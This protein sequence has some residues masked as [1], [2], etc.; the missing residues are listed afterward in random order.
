MAATW[1]QAQSSRTS[2]VTDL[3]RG[4]E[5]AIQGATDGQA[6]GIP[7]LST[8]QPLPRVGIAD[9]GRNEHVAPLEPGSEGIEGREDIGAAVGHTASGVEGMTLPSRPHELGRRIDHTGLV[10]VLDATEV[11]EGSNQRPGVRRRCKLGS[12][13]Q[14]GEQR[15]Y[16]PPMRPQFLVAPVIGLGD[17]AVDAGHGG[18]DVEPGDLLEQRGLPLGQGQIALVGGHHMLAD[19]AQHD[20][21]GVEVAQRAQPGFAVRLLGLA[22]DVGCQGVEQF[23]RIVER[24]G[25]QR[26]EQSRQSGGAPRLLERSQVRR[27]GGAGAPRQASQRCGR[28]IRS[29]RQGQAV[30][31]DGFDALQMLQQFDRRPPPRGGTEII[32]LGERVVVGADQGDQLFL[33]LG[34]Q[35]P[36]QTLPKAQRG[37]M[38]HAAGQA[39]QRGDAGEQHFVRQ[40]PGG[41][42]VEQQPGPVIARPAQDIEPPGQS[43]PGSGIILEVAKPI[44]LA[45]GRG[46]PP[47]LPTIAVGIQA[48]RLSLP[49]LARHGLNHGRR[50]LG[51]IVEKSAEEARRPELDREAKPVMRTPHPTDQLAVGGIE[52]EVASELLLVGIAGVAAVSGKLFVGQKAA[53]HRVRNSGLSQ[54]SGRGPKIRHLHAANIPCG[55]STS[56]DK[57]RTLVER[58]P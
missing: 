56:C 32:E 4:S 16:P 7:G 11:V 33:L 24:R 13:Q 40:Q 10:P 43:E 25:F 51:R 38:A 34:G 37:A 12:L 49:E 47:S 1:C 26:L 42:P 3:R 27:L 29:G 58:L 36:G 22:E 2:Q 41:R 8:Q 6:C 45:D 48:R 5:R 21:G 55:I 52:M 57:F 31:A 30:A 39:F 54:K 14:A 17:Q 9:A 44:L 20:G 35:S 15:A 53:R 46:V 23:H 18:L 19:V 28:Q 50:R